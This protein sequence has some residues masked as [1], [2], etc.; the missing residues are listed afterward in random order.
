MTNIERRIVTRVVAL[1]AAKGWQC[2]TPDP[3]EK[4]E[5]TGEAFLQ[6]WGMMST[7]GIAPFKNT[8]NRITNFNVVCSAIKVDGFKAPEP[9][10]G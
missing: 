1:L 10:T 3:I 5:E 8:A 6:G 7:R 9:Y 2:Q 4:I